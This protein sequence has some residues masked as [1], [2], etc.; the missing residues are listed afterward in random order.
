MTK[1]GSTGKFAN[2]DAAGLISVK[3][4]VV[5]RFRCLEIDAAFQET[6]ELVIIAVT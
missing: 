2:F 1:N 6:D 3:L 5:S 4:T